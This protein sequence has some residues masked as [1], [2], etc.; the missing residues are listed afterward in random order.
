MAEKNSLWKN[1][2]NKAKQ[3]RR[4][5]ATPKK[6]TAEMLRQERKIKAQKANGGYMYKKGGPFGVD[7]DENKLLLVGDNVLI[8]PPL[9]EFEV[10]GNYDY[11][12]KTKPTYLSPEELG[13]RQIMEPDSTR[14]KSLNNTEANSVFDKP[15]KKNPKNPYKEINSTKADFIRS[16]LPVP[17]NVG[18]MI[19]KEV[20]KDARMSNESLSDEEKIVLWNTIQ[21][22]KK[23]TGKDNGGTEYSDYESEY[24]SK[25]DFNNWFN[26]GKLGVTD[27]VYNSISNPGFRVA[28]T[29]GRGRYWTDPNNPDNIQYTDVYDWNSSEKNYK[30]NNLYQKLRNEVRNNEQKNLDTLKNEPYRM[31]FSFN[32]EEIEELIN[33]QN[34]KREID[35]AVSDV[36]IPFAYGGPMQYKRG[37]LLK[38]IG[39][40]VADFALGTIGGV[41]GIKSMKDI[42]NEKQYSNDKFDAGA[43][44]AG[45]IGST[46]LKLIPVTAPIANA[47]GIVGGAANKAFGIDAA[48]YNPNQE[49]SDLEKAGNIVGQAG[50]VASMFMGNTSGVSAN[51]GKFMQGV[52]KINK[53]GQSPAGQLLNQGL[54][55]QQGGNI[56]NNSV[57]LQNSTMKRY[58]DYKTKYKQGGT[59]QDKLEAN[60]IVKIPSYVGYHFEHPDGGQAMGP[61][62]SVERDELVQFAGGGHAG[63]GTPEYVYPADVNNAANTN[64]EEGIYMPQMTNDYKMITDKYGM[65][66][67]SKKSPAKWLEEQLVKRNSEFRVEVDPKT[68]KSNDQ[69]IAIAKGG[70]EVAVSVNELKQQAAQ[71][72]AMRIAMADNIAA[73]GGYLSKYRNL[74]MPKSKAN[75]GSIGDDDIIKND[76][77]YKVRRNIFDK[78]VS[79]EKYTDED[80]SKWKIKNKYNPD[81]KENVKTY[82]VDGKF[83]GKTINQDEPEYMPVKQRIEFNNQP[84]V[85]YAV[86][87]PLY[88][89]TD[90]EYTYAHGGP[91]V[92]N[93]PQDFDLYAQNRGGMMMADGGMMMPQDDG[94]SK[95]IAAALQQGADPQQLLQQLI[96]SGMDPQQAQAMLQAIM[97]NMQ[98]QAPTQAPMMAMGGRTPY[99]I[100]DNPGGDIP[101]YAGQLGK[102]SWLTTA[103]GIG[104][105]IPDVAAGIMS[106]RALKKKDYEVKPFTVEGPKFNAEPIAIGMRGEAASNKALMANT[107]RNSGMTAAGLRGSLAG[108]FG[109]Q[110]KAVGKGLTD[111]YTQK[112][113]IEGQ[114]QFQ[115]DMFNAKARADAA[116]ATMQGKEGYMQDILTAGQG[117]T[118]KLANYYANR[119]KAGMQQWQAENTQS[120]Y[121]KYVTVD[122]KTQMLFM[123]EDGNYR[124]TS[125]NI[126]GE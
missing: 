77:S 62:A 91:V 99:G 123:D 80:G 41:T 122:G 96:D 117:M 1:I 120:P 33:Q 84:S 2:R 42:V 75:G 110:S 40:G 8:A 30:G 106:A 59:I 79:V 74:S 16:A 108:Y 125:G 55:F 64:P 107:L 67:F 65:P 92:S 103:A 89:N 21:N 10:F 68:K 11:G 35:R 26:R 109:D 24:G 97:G 113:N 49:V 20:F 71:E 50:N 114:G 112:Y 36:G 44:F 53:F 6:P 58:K 22:A 86:G 63:M 78:I 32:K 105:V 95:Q 94:M 100:L 18:Q 66:R 115:A 39:L 70:R 73:Y 88:G 28:S 43:N 116:A 87:G 121:Y 19:S 4:T 31:N 45:S 13:S 61:N 57:N 54:S 111:L 47:A 9:P 60:G 3:N 12:D 126:V 23:R 85:I 93:V 14:V 83:S 119:Q 51:A 48:N 101:Q 118:N 102:E 37:G 90:S 7:I 38:D 52:D 81:T 104:Q 46:A 17:M 27:L 72:D 5:G 82:W 34:R 15:L 76:R 98:A 56:N 69:V 25:E 29:V 124:D